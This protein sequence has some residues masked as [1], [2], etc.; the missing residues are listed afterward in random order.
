MH[1]LTPPSNTE[2]VDADLVEQAKPGHGIAS[3]DPNA[4]AQTALEPQDADREASSV[5]V[6]GGVMAGAATGAA[7]GVAVAGPVGV[8]VGVS[9]GAVAGALGGAAAGAAAGAA[10]STR[11]DTATADTVRPHIDD[12]GVGGRPVVQTAVDQVARISPPHFHP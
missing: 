2:P 4:A 12:S 1:P 7:I 6:G 8:L 11:V 9:L 10:D 3:Q 5:L